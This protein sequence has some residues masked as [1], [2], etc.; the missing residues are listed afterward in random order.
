MSIEEVNTQVVPAV[1]DILAPACRL[2][3]LIKPQF[4]A[5]KTQACGL[6]RICALSSMPR[7]CPSRILHELLLAHQ[8]AFC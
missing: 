8:G 3:L 5:S 7:D 2:I 1:A 4:E 6:A